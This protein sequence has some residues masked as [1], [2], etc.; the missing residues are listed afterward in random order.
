[1]CEVKNY[2]CFVQG[3]EAQLYSTETSVVGQLSE[4]T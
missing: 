1:M 3:G 4:A 2:I